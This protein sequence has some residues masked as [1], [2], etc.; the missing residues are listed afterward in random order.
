MEHINGLFETNGVHGP[1]R[2][3]TV[4]VDDFQNARTVRPSTVSPSG[5]Y[6]APISQAGRRGF[7]P[8]IF[9]ER[10]LHHFYIIKER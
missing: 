4:V 6:H 10:V 7:L 5:V 3:A 1:V 2:I 9:S 8:R